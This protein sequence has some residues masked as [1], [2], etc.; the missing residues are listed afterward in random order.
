MY[1][2]RD[3][4][5]L[6]WLNKFDF[7]IVVRMVDFGKKYAKNMESSLKRTVPKFNFILT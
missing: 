3:V 4:L 5:V 6:A 2:V 7:H 1:R